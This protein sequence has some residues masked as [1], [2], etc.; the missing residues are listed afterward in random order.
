MYFFGQ[1]G[2]K[3]DIEELFMHA[4]RAEFFLGLMGKRI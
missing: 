4:E 1:I 3:Y 2:S